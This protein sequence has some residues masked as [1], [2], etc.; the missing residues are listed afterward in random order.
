M[1]TALSNSTQTPAL[2]PANNNFANPALAIPALATA[3]LSVPPHDQPNVL[4]AL[5]NAQIIPAVNNDAPNPALAIKI[6]SESYDSPD[7]INSTDLHENAYIAACNHLRLD[8][9][10]KLLEKPELKEIFKFLTSHTRYLARATIRPLDCPISLKWTQGHA[11]LDDALDRFAQN[12]RTLDWK[13]FPQVDG[14]WA[15]CYRCVGK[16]ELCHYSFIKGPVKGNSSSTIT[17]PTFEAFEDVEDTCKE[18]WDDILDPTLSRAEAELYII[19]LHWWL[20]QMAPFKTSGT[21]TNFRPGKRLR[22]NGIMKNQNGTFIEI[23][24]AA[25]RKFKLG[26]DPRPFADGLSS[27]HVAMTTSLQQF[28]ALYP[29]LFR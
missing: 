14:D 13:I 26:V 15:D 23:I 16:I 12:D 29:T 5:A 27:Y 28:K 22:N 8:I 6:V 10:A 17:H 20:V 7:S 1:S 3:I 11:N 19:D 25:L 9:E 2:Q 4:P 18:I 21:E 24:I